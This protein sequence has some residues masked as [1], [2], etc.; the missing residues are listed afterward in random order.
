[1]GVSIASFI[2]AVVFVF[3]NGC[4]Q[5]FYAKSMNYK[6]K[7]TGC[8]YFVGA[9]G[10]LLTGNIVPISA[11]SET[12]TL[13]G[14]MKNVSERV[15]A[16]LIAAVVGITLGLTGTV[17]SLVDFAGV[18]VL[19]GMMAGVGLILC[20]VS[21]DMVKSEKRT[22]II[23]ML[24]ALATWIL[25]HDLVYTIATSVL[26][27]TLDYC[28]IQKKR[29][30]L[31][32]D[33]NQEWRFWKRNYWDDFKLV[34][35]KLTVGAILGALSLICLNIGSNISFGTISAGM[36]NVTPNFDV[37]TVINSAADIP[38]VLFGGM[39]LEVIISGT[40]SAPWPWVAGIAMMVLSGILL[41]SG[42]M[43][44]VAK[45]VPAQSIAGFLFVIG[46]SATLVPNLSSVASSATPLE[47]V[48]AASVTMISKN[49]FLGI[50]AG[51]IVKITGSLLGVV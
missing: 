12:I 31:P 36:A 45:Y 10:N 40:C 30:Q 33:E 4:T 7:P 38:S 50:V 28:V 24:V 44:R 9:V 37:I 32:Q 20:S 46:F 48:V 43:V 27:S 1:M 41:L 51:I 21:V 18:T 42:V 49:A 11:Q 29:V 34:K 3:I 5:I 47:G 2:L 22:G 39:P 19:Y 35:P 16:L 17:S 25:S 6:I 13:G 23:S 14:L 15:M 8:A 26:V